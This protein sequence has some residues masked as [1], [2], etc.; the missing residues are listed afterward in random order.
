MLK[1]VH[2][3]TYLGGGA[4]RAAFRLHES[5]LNRPGIQSTFITPVTNLRQ[6]NPNI[7]GVN[8]K[9]PGIFH[10]ISNRLGLPLLNSQKNFRCTQDLKGSFEI[11]SMPT[12]DY[13]LENINAIED[14]DIINLHWIANFLNFPTFFKR[15]NNKPIVWTLHD[16]NPFMGGFHY[17]NDFL[18]NPDYHALETQF[19]ELKSHFS[20][21]IQNLSI[22]TPSQWL[23]D[24]AINSNHYSSDINCS[25]IP[26]S[27]NLE[28]FKPINKKES[29]IKLNIDPEIPCILIIAEYLN[30]HRKGFDLLVDALKK[31]KTKQFQ[32]LTI[33]NN[34][35]NIE[36]NFQLIELGSI[37]ND[38][39]L[40]EAYSAADLFILP[41]REDNLPNVMLE[42]F[43]CGTPVLSFKTGGMME[44]IIPGFNGIFADSNDAKGLKNSIEA[45][46][47]SENNFDQQQIREFAIRNFSADLQ[48]DKYLE[49][50]Y[51]VQKPLVK[52]K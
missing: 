32:L 23:M 43:A 38:E 52:T 18:N 14:A 11:F 4:G 36:G 35:L 27:L 19:R 24:E 39:L 45:F 21:K 25:V 47:G 51:S 8:S 30:N 34:K 33:G 6:P 16:M 1:V 48:A 13:A 15:Y 42:A 41:S 7:I 10:K 5:L 40:V 9:K 29:K 26:Y 22:I 46:I 50:Y 3:S 49:V 31:I 12:S 28:K 44:W 37:S 17:K 2:I 20:R